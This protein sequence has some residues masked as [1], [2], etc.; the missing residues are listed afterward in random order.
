MKKIYIAGKITNEPNHKEIFAKAEGKL[1]R[2]GYTVLNPATLPDGMHY[3][4]YMEICFSMIRQADE[5]YFIDNWRD[6]KSV[7]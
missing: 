6:R 2:E 1:K 3:E 4:D 7:V 5:V